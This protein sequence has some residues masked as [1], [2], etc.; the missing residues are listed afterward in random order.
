MFDPYAAEERLL[1][2]DHIDDRHLGAYLEI[3]G[4]PRNQVAYYR[5]GFLNVRMAGLYG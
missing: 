4:I 3:S 2:G 5:V 1:P